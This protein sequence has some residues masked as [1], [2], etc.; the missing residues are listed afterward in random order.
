MG[1]GKMYIVAENGM[2]TRLALKQIFL[3]RRRTKKQIINI[4]ISATNNQ[5]AKLSLLN[6]K[7]KNSE[8]K[9]EATRLIFEC[10]SCFSI[11]IIYLFIINILNCFILNLISSN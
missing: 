7:N 8:P 6:L 10:K 9:S 11:S 5:W 1:C 2:L 3:P 4:F